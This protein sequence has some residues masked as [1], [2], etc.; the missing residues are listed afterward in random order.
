MLFPIIVIMV[1]KFF[2]QTITLMLFLVIEV[3]EI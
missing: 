1:T 2:T 3:S